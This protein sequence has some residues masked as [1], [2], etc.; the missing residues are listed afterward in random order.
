M[1]EPE[2]PLGVGESCAARHGAWLST[3]DAC[4]TARENAGKQEEGALLV[5]YVQADGRTW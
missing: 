2:L 4:M 5:A 1:N 3:T